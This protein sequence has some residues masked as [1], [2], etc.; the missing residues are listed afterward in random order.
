MQMFSL[1]HHAQSPTPKSFVLYVW[2]GEKNFE[3]PL[4]I[5]I[6]IG[7]AWK[8]EKEAC[9]YRE[10]RDPKSTADLFRDILVS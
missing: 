6:L 4:R 1:T 5:D 7:D 3:D 10:V 8:E 9:C 2:S